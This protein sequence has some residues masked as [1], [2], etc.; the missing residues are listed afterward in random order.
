MKRLKLLLILV[1]TFPIIPV[2][3]EIV[4][5]G[6]YVSGFEKSEFRPCGSDDRWWLSGPIYA[7]IEQ[8][9]KDHDL[10]SGDN[11]RIPN[12]PLYIEVSGQVTGE[13]SHG[14]LGAYIREFTVDKILHMSVNSNCR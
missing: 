14:H 5:R 7:E 2:Y 6:W 4:A 3:A 12:K 11:D 13:G 8:F 1:L 10:R 9:I